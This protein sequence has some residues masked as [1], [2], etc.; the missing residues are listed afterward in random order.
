MMSFLT[1]SQFVNIIKRIFYYLTILLN[2]ILFLLLKY[3][4]VI[5]IF[6]LLF[7][8]SIIFFVP[9]SFSRTSKNRQKK[10]ISFGG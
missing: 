3:L 9:V 10:T 7:I 8:T 2:K 5:H 4:P 6:A 1:V